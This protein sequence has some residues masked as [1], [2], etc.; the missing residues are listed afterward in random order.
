MPVISKIKWT[1]YY[2]AADCLFRN[3]D[4]IAGMIEDMPE[5]DRP[6]IVW[7]PDYYQVVAAMYC[8]TQFVVSIEGDMVCLPEYW[9]ATKAFIARSKELTEEGNASAQRLGDLVHH[10]IMKTGDGQLVELA[11]S[12]KGWMGLLA[13]RPCLE[14][15]E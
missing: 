7:K 9:E 15:L 6:E 2:Q 11:F 13:G 10:R 4:I 8:I 5:K 12:H 1:T 3:H 14:E